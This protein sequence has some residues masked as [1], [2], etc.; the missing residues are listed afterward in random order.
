MTPE[1]DWRRATAC[2]NGNCVEVLI[3]GEGTVQ[4]RDSKLGDASPIITFTP[5][6]WGEL[7]KL[8]RGGWSIWGV[9]APLQFTFAE[10]V[11]FA[12]GVRNG[13][14]DLPTEAVAQ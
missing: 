6:D 13:E 12:A 11:A 4:V 3:D 1:P 2:N 14:F 8:A 9:F 10:R 7:L 5:D